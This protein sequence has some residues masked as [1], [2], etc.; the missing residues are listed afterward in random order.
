MND[1]M[2]P[3]ILFA[4]ANRNGESNGK[5]LAEALLLSSNAIPQVPRAVLSLKT[6]R[7]REKAQDQQD[8]ATAQEIARTFVNLKVR[9]EEDDLDQLPSLKRL[10]DRLAPEDRLKIINPKTG[11]SPSHA[12]SDGA[13]SPEP[14]A[15]TQS[16][17][18]PA[19]INS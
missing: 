10:V 3:I 6:T 13:Q 4:L 7:D 9:V 8:D 1:Q 19:R 5:D 15:L 18:S 17:R 11:L 14:N 2:L 12:G 16:R